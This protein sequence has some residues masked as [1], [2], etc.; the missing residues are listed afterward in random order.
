MSK[1]TTEVRYICEQKSGLSES[2]GANSIDSVINKSWNK[3]FTTSVK[4]FDESYKGGLCKKILKHYYLREI[5]CE[6]VGTWLVWM[7]TK[8]EEIMPYYNQLYNS[9]K[10]IYEPFY[11]VDYTRTYTGSEDGSTTGNVDSTTNTNS[12]TKSNSDSKATKSGINSV[13]SWDLYSDTPQGSVT[14]L[15]SQSY[16]TNARK[17]S[18]NENRTESNNTVLTSND[19]TEG[20]SVIGESSSG[21]SKKD[22]KHTETVKGKQG[23]K[24]YSALLEEYRNTFLNIDMLVIDEFEELFFKLW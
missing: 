3:I 15:E 4:F 7:N 11:D 20:K 9:A 5:G 18:D 1:Y 13:T 2:V 24:S 16:L 6:T 8:L 22:S 14:N 17:N 19:T 21:T 12:S 23:G 10:I